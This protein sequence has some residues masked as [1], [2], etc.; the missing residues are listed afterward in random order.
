MQ[1]QS[2][3]K[4]IIVTIL[5]KIVIVKVITKINNNVLYHKTM[6]CTTLGPARN[7]IIES[8]CFL[9]EKQEFGTIIW[10]SFIFVLA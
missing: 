10:S 3:L 8:L 7:Y 1:K 9:L 6:T 5:Y 2:K 4:K